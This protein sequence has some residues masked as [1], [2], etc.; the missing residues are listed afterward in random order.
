[1]AKATPINSSKQKANAAPKPSDQVKKP[2]NSPHKLFCGVSDF[3][4][5]LLAWVLFSDELGSLM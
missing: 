3:K 2:T 5:G 1:M 4:L